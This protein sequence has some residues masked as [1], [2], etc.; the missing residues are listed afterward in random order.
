[1]I[2][3]PPPPVVIDP[4]V[5]FGRLAARVGPRTE[6][7]EVVV[8]G[9]VRARVRLPGG[10]RQVSAPVPVGDHEVRLRARG[11]AGARMSRPVRVWVLPASGRRAGRVP[12][13]ADPALQ[14]DAEALVARLPAIGGVYVQHLVTGC[15]AAVNAGAQFPAAST[16]K[17]GILLEAVRAAGGAPGSDLGRLLDD[18]VLVSDDR[19]ANRVLE[20]LGGGSGDLG[21][22]RVTST[23]RALGLT[24]TLVRRPYLLDDDPRLRGQPRAQEQDAHERVPLALDARARPELRT[25]FISTPFD[26][27]RLMVA[28]HRGAMGVGAVPRLGL[29]PR[30][31]RTQVT[32]RL[33]RVRD[34]TKLVAGL[35]PGVPVAHKS[36]YTEEVKHDAGIVYLRRG[37]VVAVAMSWSASG[38]GDGVGDRFVADV[39]RAA[40]ARLAGGGRC[41]GLPLR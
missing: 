33:L 37:P 13:W 9:R 7:L 14:R 17:A 15:G 31:V 36:G 2:A 27:A 24:D 6:V 4:G 41:G 35:A 21:A 30:M 29:T 22:A 3:P 40:A 10:P 16:L 18:M 26:L 25:N 20:R 38:V 19:S 1:V 28:L 23:L 34:T 11:P 39:A 8:D 12:G 5:V 32:A